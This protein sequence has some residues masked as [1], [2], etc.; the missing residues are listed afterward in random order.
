MSL[1]SAIPILAYLNKAETIRFYTQLGFTCN[2]DWEGYLMFHKDQIY[3]HLWECAD[4]SIP[5]NTGC[6]IKVNE[7]EALYEEYA[8]FKIIHPE[9]ALEK[10]PWE[11]LQFSILDNSGNIIHFG[12]EVD[13]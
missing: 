9:G 5:K 3:L 11:M 7:I 10:K 13:N 1:Q 2:A 4:P 12:Q 6:Y 8:K